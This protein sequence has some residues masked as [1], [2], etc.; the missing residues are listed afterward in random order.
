MATKSTSAELDKH[1]SMACCDNGPRHGGKDMPMKDMPADKKM[2]PEKVPMK[3]E[4]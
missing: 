2:P 4:K 1:M 3:G